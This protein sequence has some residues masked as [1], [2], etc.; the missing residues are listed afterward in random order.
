MLKRKSLL[1]RFDEIEQIQDW[2]IVKCFGCYPWWEFYKNSNE[3]YFPVCATLDNTLLFFIRDMKHR[4]GWNEAFD[5]GI[6]EKCYFHDVCIHCIGP[7]F[8]R[9]PGHKMTSIWKVCLYSMCVMFVTCILIFSNTKTRHGPMR[10]RCSPYNVI[11]RHNLWRQTA[12][13]ICHFI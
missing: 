6:D 3:V 5:M 8:N 4:C 13:A 10:R 7:F 11:I 9:R 1:H 12:I 2:F